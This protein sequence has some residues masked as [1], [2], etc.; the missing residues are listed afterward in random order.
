[1]IG[2]TEIKLPMQYIQVQSYT[3]TSARIIKSALV[4][5]A[6]RT[7]IF[8]QYY[9]ASGSVVMENDYHFCKN[10]ATSKYYAKLIL[11]VIEM[12]ILSGNILLIL[13]I[14]QYLFL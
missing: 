1:M 13:N 5:F 7:A 11:A 3:L 9:A 2:L 12:T 10:S 8:I 14:M 6:G 4:A